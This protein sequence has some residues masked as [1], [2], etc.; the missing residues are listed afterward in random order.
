[1]KGRDEDYELGR[2]VTH[3]ALAGGTKR[4]M[5][6]LSV[7]LPASEIARLERIGRESGKTLSQVVRDAV[8]SY[9]TQRPTTAVVLG[10]GVS[11]R[12]GKPDGT[13]VNAPREAI[14]PDIRPFAT[15]AAESVM[16]WGDRS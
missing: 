16:V 15:G 5:A 4:D 13:S 10:N 1:M 14:C 9:R 12:M 2:D 6:V 11:F 3:L 8:A 7:R